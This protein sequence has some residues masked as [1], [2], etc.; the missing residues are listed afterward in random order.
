MTS[1]GINKQ[2]R[3]ALEAVAK[4]LPRFPDGRIDY[5]HA[6]AAIVLTCFV[7]YQDRLLFLKRSDKVG[8][9]RGKWHTV[10][11]YIDL[12]VPLEKKVR[13]ELQ[14]ELGLSGACTRAMHFGEP[15]TVTD[16]P[17]ETAWTIFPVL[18]TC[19]QQP[20]IRLDWEHTEYRWITPTDIF[21]YDRVHQVEE[22]L[23]RVWPG[24]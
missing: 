13:E 19:L 12:F 6:R 16:G 22:S 24:I 5:T 1:V 10:A 20:D 2:V 7:R 18:V 14:E 3:A 15:Y 8:A 17:M 11:G 4:E 21:A 9:F 23:R